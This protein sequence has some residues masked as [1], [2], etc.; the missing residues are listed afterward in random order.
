MESQI[1]N[2]EIENGSKNPVLLQNAKAQKAFSKPFK[3]KE[4]NRGAE[5]NDPQTERKSIVNEEV[6][7]SSK[8]N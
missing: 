4:K 7:R 8:N 3:R 5:E 6:Q 2:K 1:R